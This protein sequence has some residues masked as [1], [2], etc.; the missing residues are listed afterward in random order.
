MPNFRRWIE[1]KI[2]QN[3]DHG[4]FYDGSLLSDEDLR[5]LQHQSGE[6]VSDDDVDDDDG[7]PW[8]SLRK[9]LEHYGLENENHSSKT[10]N[11][12]TTAAAIMIRPILMKLASRY[13]V[14]EKHRGAPLDGVA[15]FHVGNGAEVHRVNFAADPSR[16]GMQNSF[17]MMVNYRYDDL[18]TVEANQKGFEMDYRIPASPD[19]RKWLPAGRDDTL[20][21][22]SKTRSKL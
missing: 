3:E 8:E 1:D 15:R 14:L 11:N 10:M 2:H 4:K 18:E 20:S 16:K 19:V 21:L 7:D 22:P 13:L 9:A 12:N 6:L 17:G 5:Q